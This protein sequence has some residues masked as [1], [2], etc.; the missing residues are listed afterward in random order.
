MIPVMGGGGWLALN[1]LLVVM[2]GIDEPPLM[3][4][5]VTHRLNTF[6]DALYIVPQR[7]GRLP[8]RLRPPKPRKEEIYFIGACN[9]PLEVLDPALTRPGRMGRHIYFRTP[10]WEDR[11]DIFD[12][13]MSKVAHDEELDSRAQARRA[14]AHHDRLLAGDDRPG[15]L[16]GAHLR[17]LRRARA[18]RLERPARGDDD[19]RVG[20][21]DR[22][23]LPEARGAGDRDPR[24]RPRGLLAPLGE[25]RL[26]TR[27][28][29]RRRGY[30]GGH[31]QAMEIE[32]RFVDWRSEQVGEMIWGLGAIA[33]EHVFYGQN[34]TGVGG[35]VHS[36][37]TFT[38]CS[39][40]ARGRWAR[41]ASTSPSASRTRR[42]APRRSS[43]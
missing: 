21:R 40:S 1:Q 15:L 2:D 28:S 35:D 19:R 3:K 7:I 37:T 17:A 25:N 34:T 5:F 31:H 10:T 38:P 30:S 20:R 4:K 24:G 11:R 13:Y 14:R 12:L 41:R 43:A 27:L 23:G 33:A 6:L 26:S 29:I 8:L 22:P 42:A 36:V 16:D 39:W 18:V 9:V 32:D